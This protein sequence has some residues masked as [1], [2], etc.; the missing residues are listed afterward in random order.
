MTSRMPLRNPMK[1]WILNAIRWL[2]FSVVAG[3]V[4]V[5]L[6]LATLGLPAAWVAP[7]QQRM[8][9]EGPEVEWERIRLHW[10][11]LVIDQ[12]F[13]FLQSDDQ[14]PALQARR[15]YLG[16]QLFP[17]VQLHSVGWRDAEVRLSGS[18]RWLDSHQSD[19]M[20]WQSIDGRLQMREDVASLEMGGRWNGVQLKL[21]AS[22]P[23]TRD[24]R[25]SEWDLGNFMERWR[26]AA[27]GISAILEQL[28]RIDFAEGAIL[29]VVL[30][31]L[32]PIEMAVS[33]NAGAWSYRG[34][35]FDSGTLSIIGAENRWQLDS[36][37]LRQDHRRLRATGWGDLESKWAEARIYSSLLP[38]YWRNLLPDVVRAGMETARIHAFGETEAELH[39]PPGPWSEMGQVIQG[40]LAASQL[41]AHG[42]WLERIRLDLER[43]PNQWTAR[44]ITAMVGR[45]AEAGEATG[46][47]S[48]SVDE[49]QFAGAAKGSFHPHA[50]LPVAE[51]SSIAAEIISAMQFGERMPSV[52]VIFSGTIPPEPTF[53]F[54]GTIAGDQFV[55]KGSRI[56]HFDSYFVVTNRIMRID[57]LFAARAEGEVRGR[58]EQRFDDQ[59]IDMHVISTVDPRVLARIGEG[60]VERILRPFRFEG[61]VTL[62]LKGIVD[63]DTQAQTDYVAVGD[64]ERIGW[65]WLEADRCRMDW[66]AKGNT[67]TMTNVLM[68]SYGGRLTGHLQLDGVGSD[69]IRYAGRAE[70]QAVQFPLL[71][72][73]ARQTEEDLQAG[74]LSGTL[75]FAGLAEPDWRESISGQG[76]VHIRD[77]QVF[78]IPL[79]GGLSQLLGRLYPTLG[80]AVQTDA[81]ATFKMGERR[82]RS[83]DIRIEGNLLSL[84][85]YGSYHLDDRLNFQVQIQPLRRGRLV[86]AV[87]WVTYPVSRLLQFRLTGSLRQ[88][89]WTVDVW[90]RE[91]WWVEAEEDQ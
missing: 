18:G 14:V 51:Y 38:L 74:E 70:V 1:K 43:Q 44:N 11:G 40:W 25:A 21:H 54:S 27:D 42:V 63:Y 81:S 88:P 55:F 79:L 89:A 3:F 64:A 75:V 4:L 2:G 24:A 26:A 87:R 8:S 61:P 49:R 46:A 52:D 66:I 62:S 77:G 22:F 90:P 7:W 5:I 56:E 39:F 68:D 50:V 48:Y 72:R 33:L 30:H 45:G 85:A 60:V 82:I 65:R 86:E 9:A 78:Q 23:E 37:E 67:I 20:V 16:L 53:N 10:R 73:G 15:I 13:V 83:D 32:D 36:F 58:Y 31:A 76:L 91:W 84:R 47:I 35:A 29:D 41:E 57:P 59:I 6:Y 19:W 12:P 71:L 34:V 17:V 80:F 28:N 69:S